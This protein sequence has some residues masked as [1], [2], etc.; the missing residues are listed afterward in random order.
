[1]KRLLLV[2]VATSGCIPSP[3]ELNNA[4]PSPD[5]GS[6]EDAGGETL[7]AAPDARA[8]VVSP[9]MGAADGMPDLGR[10]EMEP[11]RIGVAVDIGAPF[12]NSGAIRAIAAY[13]RFRW[14]AEV[15]FRE[16][17]GF[18]AGDVDLV[19]VPEAN[20]NFRDT[21]YSQLTNTAVPVVILGNS[22]AATAMSL[23]RGT[24]SEPY[25]G[26]TISV[27][28]AHPSFP[29]ALGDFQITT[30]DRAFVADEELGPGG[31]QIGSFP[32]VEKTHA[33]MLAYD[34]DSETHAGPAASRRFV[35]ATRQMDTLTRQ[36]WD[37]FDHVFY[38]SLEYAPPAP[39]KTCHLVTD[40][41][42]MD[43]PNHL[44]AIHLEQRMRLLGCEV[45]RVDES[46]LDVAGS[47]LVVVATNSDVD[48]VGSALRQFPVPVVAF[49]NH[50]T[51]AEQMQ[52]AEDVDDADSEMSTWTL[53]ADVPQGIATVTGQTFD[54][55][56]QLAPFDSFTNAGW[57]AGV[58]RW[59][60]DEQAAQDLVVAVDA[61]ALLT[62][63]EPSGS[64]RVLISEDLVDSEISYE[65][66]YHPTEAGVDL[67]DGAMRWAMGDLD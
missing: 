46:S 35:L 16:P 61:D 51:L 43:E 39:N 9:D 44:A 66:G 38:W 32:P 1:M 33:A 30:S 21:Q 36:A 22:A 56:S 8:D 41:D 26:S 57:V 64:R 5:L 31:V 4:D 52:F 23:W 45:I 19:V 42:R 59:V 29:V 63:G 58:R 20:Q 18:I 15:V 12:G 3:G 53:T 27:D 34:A 49:F 60:V 10:V 47:D 24:R 40:L 11:P 25:Y 17:A 37:A 65:F 2:L 14:D 48:G 13:L 54:V 7:D 67:V 55:G 6:I 50:T 28:V 62:N